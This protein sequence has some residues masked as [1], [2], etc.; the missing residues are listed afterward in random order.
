MLRVP[1]FRQSPGKCGPTVLRMV[2][3]Y[4][5]ISASERLL[6]RLTGCKPVWHPEGTSAEGIIRG[7]EHYGLRGRVVD[8]ADIPTLKKL[9]RAGIPPIVDWFSVDEGHYS[10]VVDVTRSHVVLRDPSRPG[11]VR[12]PHKTFLRVWFDFR[13]GARSREGLIVRRAIVVAP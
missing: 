2:L 7:A 5:G 8:G 10:V 4:H 11:Y 3:A 12:M 13:A 9:I 1:W 6:S